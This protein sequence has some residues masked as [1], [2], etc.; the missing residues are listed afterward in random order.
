MKAKNLA[1][2][3][4]MNPEAEVHLVIDSEFIPPMMLNNRVRQT[5]S[6]YAVKGVITKDASTDTDENI[7]L[8]TNF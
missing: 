5:I 8:I 6:E 3:L 7:F 2:L 4:M 1:T